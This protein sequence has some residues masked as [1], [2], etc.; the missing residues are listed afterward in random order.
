MLMD[1][2]FIR[3]IMKLKMVNSM[4]YDSNWSKKLKEICTKSKFNLKG[5]IHVV[6]T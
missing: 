1:F 5:W 2:I 6:K 4:N 3:A